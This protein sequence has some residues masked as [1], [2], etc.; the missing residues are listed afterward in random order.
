MGQKVN[1]IGFRVGIT[2]KCDTRWYADKKYFGQYLVED[3]QIRRY[4]KKNF[5]FAGI[6]RIEIERT[7]EEVEVTLNAARPGLV[8]GRQGA[9]VDRLRDALEQLVEFKV[10]IRIQEVKKPET[11]GQLVAE[12]IA[13][14]LVKRG[15]SK[16]AMKKAA[17]GSIQAGALG[18]KIKCSGR[19]G[20]AEIARSDDL[21]IGSVPCQKLCADISYGFAEARTT[22]GIIGIKVWIYRGDLDDLEAK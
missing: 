12:A 18:I 3:E 11:D 13:E 9:E 6:S 15:G 21:R 19:L 5:S 14:Q 10:N 2:R 1:P 17:E 22:M 16:R 8:I 4:I 7:A 20:G